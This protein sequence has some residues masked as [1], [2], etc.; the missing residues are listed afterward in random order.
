VIVGALARR[1]AKALFDLASA[2]GRVED[3]GGELER[4]TEVYREA[5]GLPALLSNPAYT[6]AERKAIADDLAG[7]PLGLT[8]TMRN[9]LH[10]LIE[11]GRVRGVPEIAE[12]YQEMADAAAGRAHVVVRSAAPLAEEQRRRLERGLSRVT[13]KQVTV[14]VEIDPSLI[15]GLSARVGG[16]VFDGSIRAQLAALEEELKRAS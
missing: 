14:A 9:F 12:R 11:N 10:L 15:G 3:L 13:G 7:T 6:R 8:Q 5:P 16:L 2:E 4:L 1:Y